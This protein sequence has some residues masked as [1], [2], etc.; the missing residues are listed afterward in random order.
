MGDGWLSLDRVIDA[1]V[2]QVVLTWDI[3]AWLVKV[4]NDLGL[5]L[6]K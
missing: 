2:Y 1:F 5:L 3:K 4:F 6:V